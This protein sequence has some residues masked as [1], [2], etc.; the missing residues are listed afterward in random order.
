MLVFAILTVF[1][2]GLMVGRTPEYLGKKIE[3]KEVKLAMLF[4]LA[5][6]F[7]ILTMTAIA[8]ITN[9]PEK[10]YLN[11]PG[12]TYNNTNN[13][14]AH[15]FSEILY[16]FSSATGN[17]GSAFAGLKPNTP[18]YNLTLAFAMIICRF[19]M[20]IPAVALA[21]SLAV[22]NY[23][24]TIRG[25]LSHPWLAVYRIAFKHNFN[26]RCPDLF[27]CINLRSNCGTL[28]DAVWPVVLDLRS[29]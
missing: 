8:S 18:F 17:S 9:L 2:A 7:S 4:V 22:K 16:A 13:S 26:C 28:L 15:G 25:D 20:L 14:G 29:R 24:A 21:G 5:A 11:A 12:A 1:I 6:S 23:C 3:K 19:F 10:S 27:P